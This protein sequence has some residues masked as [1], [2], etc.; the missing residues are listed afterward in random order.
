MEKVTFDQAIGLVD[1]SLRGL[2]Y[3]PELCKT[4][5]KGR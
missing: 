1:N 2:K 5:V 4:E 3:D